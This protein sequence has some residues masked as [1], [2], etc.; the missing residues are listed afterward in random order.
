LPNLGIKLKNDLLSQ[1]VFPFRDLNAARVI[2]MQM[3]TWVLK[4][5]PSS[6]DSTTNLCHTG[7]SVAFTFFA[8]R[9]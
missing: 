1:L 8:H 3:T 6:E 5:A 2:V 4:A 7:L 9:L